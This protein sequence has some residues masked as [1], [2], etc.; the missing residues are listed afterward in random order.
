MKITIPEP[1]HENWNDMSFQE[2]GRFCSVCSKNVRNFAD[3]SY[4]EIYD[5]LI[6]NKNI[7]GR[8]S[9]NQLNVNIRFLALKSL[10][11]GLLIAGTTSL[12][13]Q[14]L[15]NDDLNKIDFSKGIQSIHVINQNVHRDYFLGMPT[16]EDIEKSQPL[17]YLDS[18]KIS[19][20][21]MRKLKRENIE[22]V[23]IMHGTAA[24]EKYGSRGKE[25][26]VILITSKK[27][28]K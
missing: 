25:Y 26:G 16:A 20:E 8:F 15:K 23:E 18:K 12:A 27:K 7:C 10:A 1:C 9:E 21:K 28:E 22:S 14:Q 24:E 6:K 5:E 4:E 19:E 17:I 2:Q 13:A 3:C 11:L